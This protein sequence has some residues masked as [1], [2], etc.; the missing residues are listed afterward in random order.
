MISGQF[1]KALTESVSTAMGAPNPLPG[2]DLVYGW[3]VVAHILMI[4]GLVG[5]LF[6]LGGLLVDSR[7]F[8]SLKLKAPEHSGGLKAGTK[9][10]WIAAVIL[11][12]IPVALFF[13]GFQPYRCFLESQT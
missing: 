10:F 6:A 5:A 1:L 9:G 2:D 11:T 12:L 8:E 4:I 3:K 7:L 13:P